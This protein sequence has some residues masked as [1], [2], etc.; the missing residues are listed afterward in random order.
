MVEGIRIWLSRAFGLDLRSLALTRVSYGLLIFCDLLVRATNLEAH[1]TDQG[2]FPLD[3]YNSVGLPFNVSLHAL[4]GSLTYQGILFF[5]NALAAGALVVGWRTRWATVLCWLFMVSLHNRNFLLLNGG[6]TWM[7]IM[8]FWAIFL[9]WGER[10]SWDAGS[11]TQARNDEVYSAATAGFV[12][13][14]FLVYWMA[15]VFKTGAAWWSEGSAVHLTMALAEWNGDRA[16]YLLFYPSLMKS[17][18]FLILA[19]ELIGPFLFFSPIFSGPLRTV[20]V[21]G[22]MGFHVGLAIFIE[23]GL[24][25][26]V[27]LFTVAA[28]L[29]G[30]A[31]EA[32]WMRRLAIQ[33]DRFWQL[34]GVR[35]TVSHRRV[36]RT[37]PTSLN[38][39]LLTVTLYVLYW[40]LGTWREEL[41]PS[42]EIQVPGLLLRIDQYWGLFA[43]E[44]P[45]VHSW[46]VAEGVL[47]DGRR[48]DLIRDG[49]PLD[50]SCPISSSIYKN[51]RW[52]RFYV[53]EASEA[54]G[55]TREPHIRYLFRRWTPLFPD[56]VSIELYRM[57]QPSLLNHLDAEPSRFS[58]LKMRRDE[59]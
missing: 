20:A 42:P 59:L 43:P 44:P 49:A 36:S 25:P 50:W 33:L 38:L 58:L 17:L 26:F 46:F 3:L 39:C 54:G 35:R 56:L 12:V 51:Q 27:G 37:L 7:R 55:F 41:G 13:Q 6:D 30:W 19:F 14:V 5:L 53:G 24:F 4:N 10:W 21:L 57:S 8:L 16:Y 1:Y 2:V 23:I 34:A 28:L 52:K 9:P 18:T 11:Q 47:A 15:G 48:V 40:S 29:P 22:F 32:G 31:W 45:R